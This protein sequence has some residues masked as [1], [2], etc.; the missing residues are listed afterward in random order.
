MIFYF[1]ISY[2][3]YNYLITNLTQLHNQDMATSAP[4]APA[5]SS[6]GTARLRDK[7]IYAYQRFLIEFFLSKEKSYAELLR[8]DRE[9]TFREVL[10]AF[11]S[12]GLVY[13][14]NIKVPQELIRVVAAYRAV[15]H[16]LENSKKRIQELEN[17][18][19]ANF[20]K[21]ESS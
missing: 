2:F 6:I 11:E 7:K 19:D 20:E 18:L 21:F 17:Q 14:P 8:A 9:A 16:L 10:L 12:C 15:L 3:I 4:A 13:N 1:L 5:L